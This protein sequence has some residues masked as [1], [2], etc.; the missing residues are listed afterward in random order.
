[1]SD[2]STPAATQSRDSQ[3]RWDDSRMATHFSNV[4]NIQST[5]EQ[6]DLFFGTN[7]TWNAT[8]ERP[9][10]IELSNP[11]FVPPAVF[12]KMLTAPGKSLPDLQVI[13]ALGNGFIIS[14]M[15]W[16][17]FLAKLIDRELKKSSGY[18]LILSALSF[19]GIIHSA[20]LDG[21]MYLPWNVGEPGRQVPYQFTLAYVALALVFTLLSFLPHG[22]GP[23][24]ESEH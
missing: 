21:S 18:L 7:Q 14:A 10:S 3:L 1:M 19:F 17:A 8:D 16:A 13:L 5:R 4:V 6:V 2:T 24:L 9:L 12:D 22:A 15:L 23:S 11:E 20:R